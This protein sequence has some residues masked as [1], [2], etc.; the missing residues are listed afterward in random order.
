MEEKKLKRSLS[1]KKIAGVCAGIA[2]YFDID[3]TLVRVLWAVIS[4]V[5]GTGIIAYIVCMFVMPTD[6]DSEPK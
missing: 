6:S 2:A 5:Y 1:N 3:V 4:I